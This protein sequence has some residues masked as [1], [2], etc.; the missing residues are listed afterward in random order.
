[1]RLPRPNRLRRVSVRPVA[2]QLGIGEPAAYRLIHGEGE[3]VLIRERVVFRGT[4]VESEDL[5]THVAVK[6]E[7]LNCYI[8]AL[9][10]ALQETPEV[11][12]AVRFDPL[13]PGHS[14]PS[15]RRSRSSWL[16][17]YGEA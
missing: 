10:T 5:L 4:V 17:G 3:T 12:N 7:W 13:R 15:L 6:V 16:H 9:E 2:D 8:R 1:M 14:R 11:L